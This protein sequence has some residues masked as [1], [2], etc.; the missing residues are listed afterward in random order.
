MS[1]RFI[2]S[3]SFAITGLTGAWQPVHAEP[4]YEISAPSVLASYVIYVSPPFSSY[5]QDGLV[6]EEEMFLCTSVGHFSKPC[7]DRLQSAASAWELRDRLPADYVRWVA[8]CGMIAAQEC[9]NKDLLVQFCEGWLNHAEESD[10]SPET[11]VRYRPPNE[12]D[13][14]IDARMLAFLT[15]HFVFFYTD[16]FDWTPEERVQIFERLY[17]KVIGGQGEPITKKSVMAILSFAETAPYI[18]GRAE[19]SQLLALEESGV[20]GP[21]KEA[22]VQA[23]VHSRE[24]NLKKAADVLSEFE[25]RLEVERRAFA[26]AGDDSDQASE[27]DP[28]GLT[29]PVE[30]LANRAEL[31]DAEVALAAAKV[32]LGLPSE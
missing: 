14:L 6:S 9:G 12:N 23:I 3:V 1:I 4:W 8:G 32:A 7:E 19:S 11:F 31:E 15:H 27:A 24:S 25:E 2:L 5:V 20:D 10:L 30:R 16:E 18:Y 26:A 29:V 22:R 28:S 21:E 17:A 13:M